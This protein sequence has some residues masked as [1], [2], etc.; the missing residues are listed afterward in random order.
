MSFLFQMKRTCHRLL[1]TLKG[2]CFSLL[3]YNQYQGFGGGAYSES[4]AKVGGILTNDESFGGQL[5]A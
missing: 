5:E 3:A 2:L 1:T 4:W